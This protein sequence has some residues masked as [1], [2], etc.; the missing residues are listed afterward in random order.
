MPRARV[1]VG[2]DHALV[3]EAFRKILEPEFDV[4]GVAADGAALVSE[5]IRLKPDA[6]LV[7]IS[8]PLVNG[9]EA[10]RRIKR[11]LPETKILFLTMHSDRSYLRDAMKLG[12]SGYILKRAAGS[13][14]VTALRTVLRGKTYVAPELLKSIEDPKLRQALVRGSVP[15]LT[16]RQREILRLIADGNSNNE[17]AATLNV[18]LSTVRYHRTITMRK[19]GVFTTAELTRY[20]IEHGVIQ[21]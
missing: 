2:D 20:A 9:L 18:T 14:L 21:G 4:V 17:I 12:A 15:A 11:E 1:L 13:D 19:V 6:V 8:M 5:A 3:V 16:K 10:A 7:D